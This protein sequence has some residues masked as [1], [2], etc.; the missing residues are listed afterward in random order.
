M[1]TGTL[2]ECRI[3]SF[4]FIIDEK[5]KSK[6]THFAVLQE[7]W[8]EKKWI[9]LFDPNQKNILPV[10]HEGTATL[11]LDFV[12]SN[13]ITEQNGRDKAKSEVNPKI[14]CLMDFKPNK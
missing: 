12:R 10:M 8:G 9:K 5:D 4:E 7:K 3:C 2:T 13:V 11:E 14:L 6:G 1:F